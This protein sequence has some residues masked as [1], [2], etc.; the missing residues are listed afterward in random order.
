MESL[1]AT[2][3]AS[4]TAERSTFRVHYDF[5]ILRTSLRRAARVLRYAANR[6]TAVR[7]R[8]HL[9][10]QDPCGWRS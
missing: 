7:L 3:H 8:T 10:L 1:R 6:V 2:L 4:F 5:C 9:R